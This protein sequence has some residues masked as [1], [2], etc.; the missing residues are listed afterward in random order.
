M[1]QIYTLSEAAEVLRVHT[2]TVRRLVSAGHLASF[3][4]GQQRRITKEALDRYI[5]EQ[6]DPVGA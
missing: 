2:N 3:K 4:V 6:H 1:A 5:A